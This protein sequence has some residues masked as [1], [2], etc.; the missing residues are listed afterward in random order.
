VKFVREQRDHE[1]N[2]AVQ[3]EKIL[4]DGSDP[5]LAAARSR[6]GKSKKTMVQAVRSRFQK[7]QRDAGLVSGRPSRSRLH[8]DEV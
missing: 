3:P 7:L 1:R 6:W 2:R 8:L 5:A 4:S